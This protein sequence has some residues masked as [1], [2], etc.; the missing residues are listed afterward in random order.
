[1]NRVSRISAE[2]IRPPTTKDEARPRGATMAEAD[3]IPPPVPPASSPVS[4][5]STQKQLAPITAEVSSASQRVSE[6]R[7]GEAPAEPRT[8]GRHAS[9]GAPPSAVPASQV[10][11]QTIRTFPLSEG[12]STSNRDGFAEFERS[13]PRKHQNVAV[14]Q[15][16]APPAEEDEIVVVPAHEPTA[17][18]SLPLII[19]AG[20]SVP[21][22]QIAVS[23]SLP[24][25]SAKELPDVS[26]IIN[27]EPDLP[28]ADLER[29]ARPR[30][31]AVLVEQ[32]FEDLRQRRMDQ[33]RQRTAWLKQI[34]TRRELAVEEALSSKTD[35]VSAEPQ[36]LRIDPNAV[37]VDKASPE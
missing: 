25:T 26:D 28:N 30:D 32:V 24:M 15:Q 8:A 13:I 29:V 18:P 23:Q 10:A 12:M 7:E 27:T 9:A 35:S 4:P 33:A 19:P 36:R 2:T 11:A 21:I 14:P 22:S 6:K 37:P 31:V 16:F 34:V 3:F 17:S 1:M 5:D 20:R